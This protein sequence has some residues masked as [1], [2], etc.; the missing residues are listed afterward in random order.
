M[1]LPPSKYPPKNEKS[2]LSSAFG[3]T[4]RKIAAYIFGK[5]G[6]NWVAMARHGLI[7]WEND[8][9]GFN[10]FFLYYV[11]AQDLTNTKKVLKYA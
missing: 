5:I 10:I 9:T 7:L 11:A 4:Y 1:G 2:S 3:S 6:L 8:A